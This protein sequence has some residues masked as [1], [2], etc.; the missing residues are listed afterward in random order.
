MPSVQKDQETE[1]GQQEPEPEEWWLAVAVEQF[2]QE[3]QLLMQD[4]SVA[5]ELQQDGW[6]GEQQDERDHF[7]EASR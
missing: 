5:G 1:P 4:G 6:P 2:L 7:D 3:Q